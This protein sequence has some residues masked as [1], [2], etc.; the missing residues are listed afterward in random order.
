VIAAAKRATIVIT[1]LQKN[2]RAYL[3]IQ[4]IFATMAMFTP[5]AIA[6]YITLLKVFAKAA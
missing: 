2:A 3:T 4:R 1:A 6:L 5:N